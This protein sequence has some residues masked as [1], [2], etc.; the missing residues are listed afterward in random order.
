MQSKTFKRE[1][2]VVML[3]F[4]GWV[5]S[6]EDVA[7]VEVLA[8]PIISFT[9]IA[10]GLEWGSKNGSV[11]FNRKETSDGSGGPPYYRD[12]GSPVFSRGQRREDQECGEGSEGV[13]RHEGEDR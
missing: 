12:G 9:A 10:F 4:L 11:V 8:W 13:H 5:V 1:V 2:A 7:M 6:K 3:I